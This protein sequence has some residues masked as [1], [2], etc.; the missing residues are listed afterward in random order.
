[1]W[2]K[3]TSKAKGKITTIIPSTLYGYSVGILKRKVVGRCGSWDSYVVLKID[4]LKYAK[5]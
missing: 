4:H 2:L 3:C 1:M 5:R